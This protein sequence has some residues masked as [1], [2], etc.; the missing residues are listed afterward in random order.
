MKARNRQEAALEQRTLYFAALA[1]NSSDAV[2]VV[3]RDGRILNEA[4]NLAGMLGRPGA[5]TTGMDAIE[6]LRPD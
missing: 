6:F 1:E 5:A 2:I 3:D 4:P